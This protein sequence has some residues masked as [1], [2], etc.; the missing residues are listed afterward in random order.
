MNRKRNTAQT[1]HNLKIFAKNESDFEQKIE[2]M[3]KS[4]KK[5]VAKIIQG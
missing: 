1:R 5:K 2:Q 3:L 4:Q